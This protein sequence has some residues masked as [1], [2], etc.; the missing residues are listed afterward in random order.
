MR[1]SSWMIWLLAAVCSVSKGIPLRVSGVN[2]GMIKR[3]AAVGMGG[4]RERITADLPF[5]CHL[6]IGQHFVEDHAPHGRAQII[7]PIDMVVQ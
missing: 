1:R 3:E 4:G 2:A 6:K 5:N 7:E